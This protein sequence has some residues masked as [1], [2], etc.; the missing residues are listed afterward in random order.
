MATRSSRRS[1]KGKTRKTS[2]SKKMGK[3][4]HRGAWIGGLA[5]AG[6]A[7][8][9][10]VLLLSNKSASAAPQITPPPP[11]PPAGPVLDTTLKQTAHDMNQA[12]TA[13]G[14]V[15][16]DRFTV[17]VPFQQAAG[18]KPDGWPGQATGKA[19]VAALATI[20]E[21]VSPNYNPNY[22]FK[23]PPGFDGSQAPTETQ[24][25]GSGPAPSGGW[26]AAGS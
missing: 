12:L 17:Y 2:M 8:A 26:P 4:A 1:S 14:Y 21:P 13:H 19:L 11:P 20:P 3:H 5:L 7:T 16:D 6:A 9:A 10:A 15:S 24:F 23:N 22:T 25:Y 18:L